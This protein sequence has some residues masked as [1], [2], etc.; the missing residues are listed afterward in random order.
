MNKAEAVKKIIEAALHGDKEEVLQQQHASLEAEIAEREK[1]DKEVTEATHEDILE[2]RNE[3]LGIGPGEGVAG[4]SPDK[5][6]DR[7]A[8]E[9]ER[10]L[11]TKELRFELRDNWKDIQHL[12]QEERQVEGQLTQLAQR[13]KRYKDIL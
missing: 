1:I 8:M 9:K 11:L 3:M 12:K 5:R 2:V 13:K 4:E 6:R 10:L 7:L